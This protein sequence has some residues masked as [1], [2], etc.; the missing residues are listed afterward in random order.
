MSID[1]SLSHPLIIA[2]ARGVST[3]TEIT[4]AFETLVADP[5]SQPPARILFDA[6][7]TDYGPPNEEL[8]ALFEFLAKQAPLRA[9]RWTI[10]ANAN[11]LVFGLTRMF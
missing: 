8:E 2:A 1:F 10:V 7:Q 4:D 9:S 3:Y 5:A 6:R 11:S